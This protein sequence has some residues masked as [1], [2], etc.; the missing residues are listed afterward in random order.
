MKRK[1]ADRLIERLD[2]TPEMTPLLASF[3]DGYQ[4]FEEAITGILENLRVRKPKVIIH[5]IMETDA[6][7][8]EYV[9]FPGSGGH[10]RQ[11]SPEKKYIRPFYESTPRVDLSVE[12]FRRHYGIG[13]E[14]QDFGTIAREV[15][16]A[17]K[18]LS[19]IP[20]T[21]IRIKFIVDV[22]KQQYKRDIWY[23]TL[24]R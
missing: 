15:G 14:E 5:K 23:G 11:K 7:E 1:T 24:G 4:R 10:W 19:G 17:K 21:K 13:V 8:T 18:D 6:A 12:C 16:I 2:M 20:G 9:G 22:L 3:E